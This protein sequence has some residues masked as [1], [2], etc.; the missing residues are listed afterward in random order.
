MNGIRIGEGINTKMDDEVA[1]KVEHVSKK[2][3][4]SL[5]KS[6]LYG[7]ADIGRNAIG[8]GSHPDKLRKG[9]FWAVDDVSFEVKRGE[10]L[11]IIGPNGVGKTML[12]K[13]LNGIF[14]PDKGKI[15]IKGRVG[16]LIQVGAG[17]HPLR[18]G[19]EIVYIYAAILGMTKK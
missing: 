8:M 13:M 19:R 4:K 6:M 1:I 15:T 5:K 7:I 10:V 16:A 3:C 2:Y 17:F 18:T 9:E 14:W 12:L 11:G